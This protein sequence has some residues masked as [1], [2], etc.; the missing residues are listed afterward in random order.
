MKWWT[1]FLA[2]FRSTPEASPEKV[3]QHFQELQRAPAGSKRRADLARTIQP[4]EIDQ[5][6]QR[7]LIHVEEQTA[8]VTAEASRSSKAVQA[9]AEKVQMSTDELSSS[10]AFR[11]TPVP[12]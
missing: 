11:V 5:M 3:E 7:T 8:E 6:L 2:S 1:D 12:K 4:G 9:K 10:G